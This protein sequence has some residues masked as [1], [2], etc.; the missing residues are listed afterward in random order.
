[1]SMAIK[2][3]AMMQNRMYGA[4]AAFTCDEM[5]IQAYLHS[6]H[7]LHVRRTLDQYYYHAISTEDRDTDQVVYRYT[8]DKGKEKKLYMVDQLWLWILDK[9]LIVTAFP[10]RWQQPKNDPL[11]V[12]DG[13]IEDVNSKTRPPVKTVYD[14]AT[15]I[16]GRCSGIFDRHRLGD[17]D[18]QFLDMF[19]SSIGEVVSRHKIEFLCLPETEFC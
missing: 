14:L 8:R 3:A 9:D 2:R 5:L 1:M 15:L 17:D 18:Y 19:E 13:I 11:N 12:L 10:Q 7:N 4:D 6:T 16:T